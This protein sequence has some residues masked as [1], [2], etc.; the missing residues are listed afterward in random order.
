[1]EPERAK[2]FGPDILQGVCERRRRMD[3][4]NLPQLFELMLLGSFRWPLQ[5]AEKGRTNRLGHDLRAICLFFAF[6]ARAWRWR[7][8]CSIVSSVV[9]KFPAAERDKL[10]VRVCARD[11][12]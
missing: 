10:V 3:F 4:P 11:I 9:Q 6:F 12:S 7:G 8:V 2:R 5:I 1:M